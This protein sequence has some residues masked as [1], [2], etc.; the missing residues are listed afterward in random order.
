MKGRDQPASILFF[1]F[2]FTAAIKTIPIHTGLDVINDKIYSPRCNL[3]QEITSQV[4]KFN[5]C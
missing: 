5:L 4:N 2:F 3:T 1:N